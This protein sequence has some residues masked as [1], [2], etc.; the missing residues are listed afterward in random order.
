MAEYEY[1][2]EPTSPGLKEMLSSCSVD[3]LERLSGR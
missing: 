1:G 2:T 3:R